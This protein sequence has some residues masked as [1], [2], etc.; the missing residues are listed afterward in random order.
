METDTA[1]LAEAF[2]TFCDQPEWEAYPAPVI[3]E[4][5]DG[6]EVLNADEAL[7]RPIILTMN[8][9]GWEWHYKPDERFKDG[10]NPRRVIITACSEQWQ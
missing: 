10:R 5:P 1:Q 7:P 2:E 6:I 8:S 3:R 9:T 4:H